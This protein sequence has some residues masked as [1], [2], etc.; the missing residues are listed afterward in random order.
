MDIKLQKITLEGMNEL[1]RNFQRDP[2]T[3]ADMSLFSE[4]HYSPEETRKRFERYS[5]PDRRHFL[6]LLDGR[7]VGEIG[8]KHIDWERREGELSIHLQNDAV[9]NRGIGTKAERFL[10]AYAF[11]ELGLNAV[12]ARVIEKNTRSRHVLEKVGFVFVRQENGFLHYRFPQERFLKDFPGGGRAETVMRK[13]PFAQYVQEKQHFSVWEISSGDD[14]LGNLPDALSLYHTAELKISDVGSLMPFGNSNDIV[15]KM[16]GTLPVC[17]F[18]RPVFA[19]VCGTDPFCLMEQ[20][21]E[22]L[23]QNGVYGVQN[24]PTVG[25]AGSIF[26]YNLEAI[27]LGFRREVDMMKMARRVGLEIFPFIFNQFEALAMAEAEPAAMVCHLGV[28]QRFGEN[29]VAIP[30][31]PYLDRLQSIRE[32]LR[33]ENPNIRLYVYARAKKLADIIEAERNAGLDIDG[34]YTTGRPPKEETGI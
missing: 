5:A 28:L 19:G 34:I 10:L 1:D 25:L 23:A 32:L 6:I 21:L 2:A 29:N 11:E 16:S 30:V 20:L 33:K 15:R 24:F 9:K 7:P 18:N 17:T 3:F 22:E 26:R 14:L 12:T 8:V 4:Y 31:E 27:S 13:I